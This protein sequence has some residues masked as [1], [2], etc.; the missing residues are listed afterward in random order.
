MVGFF[1]EVFFGRIFL[2][3]FFWEEL[4]SRFLQ[5]I[6]VFV[7]ILRQFCLNGRKKEGRRILILRSAIASTLHL[8]IMLNF[9]SL[10]S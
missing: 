2:G 8:K 1:C 4:L 9:S 6:D 3:G 10:V 7:K 5:G